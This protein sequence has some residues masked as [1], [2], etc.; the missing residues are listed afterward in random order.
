MFQ[1]PV[2]L[3]L[4]HRT[5]ET[6]ALFQEIKKIKPAQLFVAGDGPN[7]LIKDDYK[8]CVKARSVIMPEWDCDLKT[9]YKEEHLG[10]SKLVYQ[11]ISWFFE[12]V[13]E[14]IILFDDTIPNSDF[15]YYCEELLEKYRDNEEVMHIGGSYIQRKKRK[16]IY[17]YYFSVYAITWG[18]ATWKSTW[19]YFN[20]NI[21]EVSDE[22]ADAVFAKYA[23]GIKEKLYWNRVFNILKKNQIAYWN[24]QYNFHIWRNNGL[25]IS[26]NVNLVKNIGI[27]SR[28]R[29]FR[30]L[31]RDTYQILPLKDPKIIE[32]NRSED[33]KFFKKSY[34]KAFFLMFFDWIN[35]I[36]GN[37][38]KL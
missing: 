36:L 17:S 18:F 25:C 10:K 22:E 19:K 24:Y 9:F 37:E 11:A 7:P 4:Y 34:N 23:L 27:K 21:S 13:E 16:D 12:H 14:G 32:R 38:K 26:P 3:I 28:R 5:D 30:R 33:K 20:L 1:V 8:H 6:H 2:L 31:M 15:F 35:N 29:G